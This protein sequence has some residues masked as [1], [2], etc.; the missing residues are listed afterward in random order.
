MSSK[1]FSLAGKIS[2]IFAA[3]VVASTAAAA[4]ISWFDL[5]AWEVFLFSL[6]VG[7]IL[8][9]TLLNQFLVPFNKVLRSVSDG[10]RSFH[11][12][13]YSVRLAARR[14]DELGDLV[15][16]YNRVG[17]IL[18]EERKAIRQKELLL[19]TALDRSP[20]ATVLV[21]PLDRVI[22]CNVEARRLFTGG[23]RLKGH[24][25]SEILDGCPAE[26]RAVL[27]GRSD[28][29]FTL[30]IEGDHE[31]YHLA[32]RNFTLNQQPHALYLL[33]RLTAELRRQEAAIWKK[34]IRIISHELNNSLAPISSLARSAQLIAED[35]GRAGK[36]EE[37]FAAIRQNADHIKT[38]LEGYARYARLP[39]PEPQQVGWE[40]FLDSLRGVHPFRLIG[41]VPQGGGW[42]DPIHM[43]QVMTNLLKNAL[44]ASDGQTD[45]I[46]VEI[47]AAGEG[48]NYVQVLDRGRGLS[49]EV[50]R[51]A[52]L[53]FY[54]TKQQGAGLGLPLCREIMEAHGGSLRIQNREGGGTVVTCWIPPK[55][56][57]R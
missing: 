24:E 2:A 46:L 4:G 44:E 34:A 55:P 7:L 3:A 53:P 37:I 32:R 49:E 10:I 5:P 35:P 13:D 11:D 54:S 48:G 19:Q 1:R 39:E 56:P 40:G 50:M 28:G 45:G 57:S 29:L 27:S 36:L 6:P 9:L 38:F 31:T 15:L 21:N 23:A 16:L 47:K 30:D 26:M 43:R 25:F 20:A 14:K 41:D 51:R 17:E 42:F 18:H 8:G 52:L 22:Y 33:R 12:R